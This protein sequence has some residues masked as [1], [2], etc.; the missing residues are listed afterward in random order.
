MINL[1]E[2]ALQKTKGLEYWV[3]KLGL[4]TLPLYACR[5]I[6]DFMINKNKVGVMSKVLLPRVCYYPLSEHDGYGNIPLELRDD[7]GK[8][9]VYLSKNDFVWSEKTLIE[10]FQKIQQGE[11]LMYAVLQNGYIQWS[12]Y[13]RGEDVDYLY[14]VDFSRPSIQKPKRKLTNLLANVNEFISTIELPESAA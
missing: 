14:L 11:R 5:S 9:K 13:Y 10:Y 4:T 6:E 1:H 3:I 12:P 8:L 2:R 7:T